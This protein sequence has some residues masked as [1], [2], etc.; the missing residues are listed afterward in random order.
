MTIEELE[1]LYGELKSRVDELPDLDFKNITDFDPL[2]AIDF[3]DTLWL[4]QAQI[5]QEEHQLSR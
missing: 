4:L 1:I 3:D 2:P 5:I